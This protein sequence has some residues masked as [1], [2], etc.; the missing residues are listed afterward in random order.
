MKKQAKQLMKAIKEAHE[1]EPLSD[2]NGVPSFND[3]EG[4]ERIANKYGL[5]YDKFE[6]HLEW[7]SSRGLCGKPYSL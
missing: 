3:Y 4:Y 5:D 1:L 6:S 7:L 2:E